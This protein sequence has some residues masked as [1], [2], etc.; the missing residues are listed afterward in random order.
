[1]LPMFSH[2]KAT[3]GT[4]ELFLRLVRDLQPSKVSLSTTVVVELFYLIWLACF[5]SLCF[6]HGKILHT[7]MEILAAAVIMTPLMSAKLAV[8]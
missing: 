4:T 3:S 2:I 1:M 6:R 8:R 5:V 7:K